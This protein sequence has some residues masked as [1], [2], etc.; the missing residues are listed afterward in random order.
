MHHAGQS[1]EELA[2]AVLVVDLDTL[3]LIFLTPAQGST[4]LA[5]CTVEQSWLPFLLVADE[6]ANECCHVGAMV[7]CLFLLS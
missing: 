7:C 3:R 2:V 1:W 6:F 5:H 4:F